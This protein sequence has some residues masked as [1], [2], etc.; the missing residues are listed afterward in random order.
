[1][2][3]SHGVGVVFDAAGV[4]LFWVLIG[5][6]GLRILLG[7]MPRFR[8]HHAPREQDKEDKQSVSD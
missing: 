6:L 2:T 5:G 7:A 3:E 4:V 1:M 8:R